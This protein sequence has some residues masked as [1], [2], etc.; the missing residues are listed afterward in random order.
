VTFKWN[1]NQ[2]ATFELHIPKELLDKAGVTVDHMQDI[3]NS[4]KTCGV[5]AEVKVI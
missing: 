3:L 2:T 5:K 4:V 1:A